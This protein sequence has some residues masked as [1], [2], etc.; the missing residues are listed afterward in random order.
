V[1]KS[2]RAKPLRVRKRRRSKEA[3]EML[4]EVFIGV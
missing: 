2:A 1:A 3:A 4:G